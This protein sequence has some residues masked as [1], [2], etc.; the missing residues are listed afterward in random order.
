[1]LL[2][3]RRAVAQNAATSSAGGNFS[4]VVLRRA[5]SAP[6]AGAEIWL[7]SADQHTVADSAGR[8][9]FVHLPPGAYLFEVRAIGYHVHDDTVTIGAGQSVVRRFVLGSATATLDTVRTVAA[10]RQYISPALRGFEE[11]RLSGNGG[12]FIPDS[13]LRNNDNETLANVIREWIPGVT[14]SGPYLVSTRKQS[15]GPA[16]TISRV[17]DCYVAVYIDGV[18]EFRAQMA[19]EARNPE[20]LRAMLPDLGRM[21]VSDYAGVEFY[22]DAASAPIGMHSDDDGCG[23][24]YLWTREK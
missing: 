7:I 16:L 15:K 11:R 22:A 23:S 1:M 13:V 14:F 17:M 3:G 12:H 8:F 18:L 20:E 24:L 6:I 19:R 4:G 9:S 2:G 10:A 5:D 21:N